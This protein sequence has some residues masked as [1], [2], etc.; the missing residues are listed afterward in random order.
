MPRSFL[1]KK[2]STDFLCSSS[3]NGSILPLA[4]DDD[5]KSQDSVDVCGDEIVD[6]SMNHSDVA[7]SLCSPSADERSR[8]QMES[9]DVDCSEP[10][11]ITDKNGNKKNVTA[12]GLR[13]DDIRVKS[14][15]TVIPTMT[16]RRSTIWSPA[17]D[18]KAEVDAA[19]AAELAVKMVAKTNG[20][21]LEALAPFTPLSGTM[22]SRQ[23]V[24][25]S[26]LSLSLSL[27]LYIYCCL[28]CTSMVTGVSKCR[29]I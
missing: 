10:E 19:A 20:L 12:A 9:P 5:V 3:N 4:V 7:V 13:S 24:G 27:Y 15:T 21:S 16:V 14:P 8:Q 23:G 29:Y 11:A 6:Y 17:A 22:A 28:H 2:K 25:K 26:S 1:I 18:I